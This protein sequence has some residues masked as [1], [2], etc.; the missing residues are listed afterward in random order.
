[1]SSTMKEGAVI[2]MNEVLP[3]RAYLL[4]EKAD[5]E[6]INLIISDSGSC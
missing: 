5:S 2:E 4:L 1:M 3:S 6:Q